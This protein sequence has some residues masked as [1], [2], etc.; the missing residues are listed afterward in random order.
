MHRVGV[1]V[2]DAAALAL[3]VVDHA[4]LRLQGVCTHFAVADEPVE[5]VH[6]RATRTVRRRPAANSRR[7]ASI[8][9]SCTPRTPRRRSRSRR[10]AA[11]SCASGSA[12]TAIAPVDELGRHRVVAARAV[13]EGAGLAREGPRRRERASRTACATRCRRDARHRDRADR[14]RRRRAAQ[15]RRTAGAKCSCA[16]G[17][18][19]SRARSRW[20]S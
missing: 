13:G 16:A 6:R 7:S 3:Q 12:S 9:A 10:R 11:T 14:V 4:E 20:T 2:H 15:P 19:P 17:A 18:A 1:G 8:P 5:P